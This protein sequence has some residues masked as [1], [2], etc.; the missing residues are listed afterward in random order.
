MSATCILWCVLHGNTGLSKHC[1]P[2]F[3][4]LCSKNQNLA[5]VRT[6]GEVLK[7]PYF[8]FVPLNMN[9]YALHGARSL[10]QSDACWACFAMC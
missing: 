10:R 1:D 6:R 7:L 2:L 9:H 8:W 3:L 5:R 4:H